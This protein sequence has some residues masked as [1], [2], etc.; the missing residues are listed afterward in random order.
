MTYKLF[1][2]ES[3]HFEKDRSSVMCIGYIKVPELSYSELYE[4]IRR[5]KIEHRSPFELKWNKFSSSRMSFY[6]ALVD[7]FFDSPLEFQCVLVKYKNRLTHEEFNS[8]SHGNFYYKMT[9]FL[10]KPTHPEN[11]YKVYLDVI[12]TRGKE[13]LNKIQENFGELHKGNSPFL[14]F[15]H[16]H[17]E[18]LF[19]QL[20]DLFVG[21]ITYKTRFTAGDLEHYHPAKAEFIN[22]LEQKAGY[23]LDEGSEPWETK[24][25]ILDHQPSMKKHGDR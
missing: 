10:L 23:L 22:Y 25:N 15:Q 18:N 17:T 16:L 13:R 4:C 19:F 11:V 5:I 12:N 24:F 7:L 2:D 3:C 9:Y 21:A 20:T 6:K 14:C 1:L 8:G